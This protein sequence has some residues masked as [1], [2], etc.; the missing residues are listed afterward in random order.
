MIPK[1]TWEQKGNDIK[2][3]KINTFVIGSDWKGK[4]DFL[5]E[6]CEVI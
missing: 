5:K 2:E 3:F 1:E 6:Y 4:F